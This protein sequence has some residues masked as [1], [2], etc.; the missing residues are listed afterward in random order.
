MKETAFKFLVCAIAVGT[1]SAVLVPFT[2]AQSQALNGQIEGTV[3]DQNKAAVPNAVIT[4]TNIESGATRTVTTDESGVYRFPLLPLG[5]YR[6]TAEANNFKKLHREG[7]TLTTGQIATVDLNLQAGEINEVVV[8]TANSS[9]SDSG[10]I[11]DGR[12]MNTREVQNLPLVPRNPYNFALLQPNVTG[13]P[14]R[15]FAF[16]NVNAN[17]FARRVNYQ[18]D[19]NTNTQGDRAGIRFTIISEVF[20]SEIQLVTN[21]FA[22]EFGNTPGLVMNVVTPSGTNAVHGSMSYRFRRPSFY[23]RPFFYPSPHDLPENKTDNFTAAVGGPIIKD[24]WH[25]YGGY[26][27]VKRDDKAVAARLLT[28]QEANKAQLIAAGLSPSI[29]PIAIPS[30]EGGSFYIFR[31]DVQLNDKNRLTGR[32]THSDVFSRNFVLGGLNTLERTFSQTSVDY[33]AGFQLATYTPKLL[34]ELRFQYAQ[35]AP[36]SRRN[37]LSGNGPSIVITGVANFGSPDN[38]DTIFPPRRITQIQDNL[39]QTVGTHV[40]K[41]GFGFNFYNNTERSPI[42]ARYTFPSIAAYVAARN[43]TDL[44]RYTNYA[45]TFG[46]PE[47]NYKATFWNLFAQDD[48]KVTRRLKVAYGLRYDLYQIPK[49]DSSSPFPASQRFNVDQNNFA[50]RLGLVYALR[51]GDRPMILRAGAGIYY[52]Q[53]LLA[54]YQRALQ[55]NG[56]S[57]F[58]SLTFSGNNNGTTIPSPNAPAFPSTLLGT[59]PAGSV[60]PPQNIDTIAPA[61][62]NMYAIHANIQMEQ[63]FTNDLSFSVGYIHSGGRHIPVYRSINLI[64]IRFLADGRPVFSRLV[65]PVTRYDPRFNNILMVESA[66]VSEYN[67]LTLQ[68]TK[69]LSRGLQFSLNYTLSEAEDDAPEQNLTTGNIQGLVLSDPFNRRLDKGLSFANQ[70]HTFVMSLVG[71]PKFNIQSKAF[72]YLLNNNQVGIIATANTGETFN[73]VSTSDINGDGSTISD[74]PVG[75]KRNSGKTPPQFNVDLRYSR[76]FNFTERYKMEV[77]GE[78][79]NLFNINSIIQFNNVTV[80][81]NATTGELIGEFPNFKARNQSTSQDSR[82]F[83]LGFKFIF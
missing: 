63:A 1:F 5:T 29:F 83:Q 77:F 48:W 34:N 14:N 56:S 80:T 39:T 33:S 13:R 7:I 32:F 67:A 36:G 57:K 10:K 71:R 46:D 20:V 59:V 38:V 76:F 6:I 44:R 61:F 41:F 18:L 8:V 73:I 28:I 74:R 62:E 31:T 54:M 47:I 49:A 42:F 9:I 82:Q 52:D 19:G 65:N 37:E 40:V 78:F 45:E 53:P 3:L 17:G 24:R 81:T 16:P 12:V 26:E 69:R 25:F 2:F 22:A 50:P 64:P 75:I 23:S 4:V 21:G 35:R 15:G 30:L 27:Y 79:Q 11:D 51:E 55:I 72:R 58:F 43:G 66:E 68:L 70:R 60:L